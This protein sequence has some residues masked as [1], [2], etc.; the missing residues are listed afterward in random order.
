MYCIVDAKTEQELIKVLPNKCDIAILH[1]VLM[2]LNI[3][4]AVKDKDDQGNACRV[5]LH[6]TGE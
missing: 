4:E 5:I 1:R 3:Y 2:E 6:T